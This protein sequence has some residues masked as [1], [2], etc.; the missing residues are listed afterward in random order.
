MPGPDLR[1]LDERIRLLQD[2]N[3]LED[4]VFRYFMAIDDDDLEAMASTLT[5]DSV[6]VLSGGTQ[7]ASH[8]SAIV[9]YMQNVRFDFT[10]TVHTANNLQVSFVSVDRATGIVG[11]HIELGLKTGGTIYGAMRYLLEF[12]RAE[13]GWRI[14][15]HEIALI[16]LGPW[17][18][19]ATSLTDEYRVRLPGQD[20]MR[21]DLPRTS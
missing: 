1:D 17:S 18:D 9:E 8:R 16:H 7:A 11:A 3:D 13:S 12:A 5:D 19:V 21:A 6:L 2:R 10:T 4:L 14:G 20:P 15:R